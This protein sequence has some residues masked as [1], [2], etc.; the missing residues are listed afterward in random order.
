MKSFKKSEWIL[1]GILISTLFISGF[2]LLRVQPFRGQLK[3]L[4]KD[5]QKIQ[6]KVNK[7]QS[8]EK[9]RGSV[10]KIQQELDDLKA[11]IE[12][13]SKTMAGYQQSF[14]DLQKNEQQAELKAQITNLIEVQGMTI[15]NIGEDSK[16]L[17]KLINAQTKASTQDIK[18]PMIS[19]SLSGNF[20]MLN[21]FFQ[22]LEELPY[23]VVITRL[24]MT[25]ERK[26]D[27]RAQYQLMTELSLA[28]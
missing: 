28:L 18:R 13:E 17:D 9:S 14:I 25:V 10:K 24:S 23:S 27:L 26:A 2:I 1:I 5:L 20:I 4:N 19:L 16:S 21:N 3:L 7:E 8:S 15:S 22:Q 6:K 12:I 11:A